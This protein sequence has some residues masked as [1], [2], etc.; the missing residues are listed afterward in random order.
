MSK[1]RSRSREEEGR[2]KR[3][4]SRVEEGGKRRSRS[5]A[6][7]K[8]DTIKRLQVVGTILKASS[9]VSFSLVSSF[10]FILPLPLTL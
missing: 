2:E 3:S 5:R 8:K 6:E 9:K 1:M 10:P 4:K 7:E